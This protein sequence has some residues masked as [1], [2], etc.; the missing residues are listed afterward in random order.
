[1]MVRCP[2]IQ[3]KLIETPPPPSDLSARIRSIIDGYQNCD[4]EGIDLLVVATHALIGSGEKPSNQISC[5]QALDVLAKLVD[6]VP[7]LLVATSDGLTDRTP[8]PD[9]AI[10]PELP[11]AYLLQDGRFTRIEEGSPITFQ[12]RQL[13]IEVGDGFSAS[14]IPS[15]DLMVR[16]NRQCYLEQDRAELD[17]IRGTEAQLNKCTLACITD[18]IASNDA[19]PRCVLS[20]YDEEGQVL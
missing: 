16:F 20:L 6:N 5:G 8:L 10:I 2:E 15:L 3:L 13:Y 1:M 4:K 17:E 18:I 19:P 12:G 9:D 11:F 7:L 14:V